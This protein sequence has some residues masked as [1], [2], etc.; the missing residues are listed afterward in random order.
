M[1]NRQRGRVGLRRGAAIAAACALG[2]LAA[3]PIREARD[4]E[5]EA[6]RIMR[7]IVENPS[8]WYGRSAVVSGEVTRIFGPRSFEIG[9]RGLL[10][11][12]RQL[13][14]VAAADV[15]RV[16]GRP[17]G[18]ILE[19]D[20]VRA[21]GTVRRFEQRQIERELGIA[22]EAP[23]VEEFEGGPVVMAT[24]FT[25]T[26]YAGNHGVGTA[27]RTVM[28]ADIA[29]YPDEFIGRTVTVSGTVERVFTPEA[30]RIG[31]GNWWIR[32]EVLVVSPKPIRV[33][34]RPAPALLLMRDVVQVTGTVRRFDREEISR[35][36]GLPLK[37]DVI[38]PLWDARP[39][40]VA[41]EIHVTPRRATP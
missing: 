36:I 3:C 39:V 13:L 22:L 26:P 9:R 35:E 17:G 33:P 29:D 2:L 40:I 32:N 23:G 11:R 15:P 5:S 12:E 30:F 41:R 28:L 4:P 34:G 31:P 6:P 37:E 8:Q 24:E 1:A 14:I 7:D 25:I 27:E 18:A 19:G 20:L 16:E 21:Q 38:E 10:R